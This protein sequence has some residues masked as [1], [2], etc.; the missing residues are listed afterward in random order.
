M[1]E[2]PLVSNVSKCRFS[3]RS[4]PQWAAHLQWLHEKTRGTPHLCLDTA[5]RLL[6]DPRTTAAHREYLMVSLV[7]HPDPHADDVLT[8]EAIPLTTARQR[9]IHHITLRRR[10]HRHSKTGATIGGRAA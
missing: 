10:L 5:R 8:D 2:R 9:F 4:A 3:G 7:D 6:R 1:P